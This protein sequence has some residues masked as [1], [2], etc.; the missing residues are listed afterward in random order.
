[1]DMKNATKTVK[2]TAQFIHARLGAKVDGYRAEEMAAAWALDEGRVFSAL[3]LL[4]KSGIVIDRGERGWFRGPAH[5]A[6]LS[7]AALL[8]AV[9]ATLAD[10]R[11][12]LDA[13]P[14]AAEAKAA[15]QLAR[16]R[17]ALKLQ[18]EA[19]ARE[20]AK[21]AEMMAMWAAQDAARAAAAEG[22]P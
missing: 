7:A 1:M 21:R 9:E 11:R 19:F 4:A 16:D 10:E 5:I 13:E 2:A 8:A 3:A 6:P 20:D 17:H 22:T 15:R 18:E 14:G 12:R